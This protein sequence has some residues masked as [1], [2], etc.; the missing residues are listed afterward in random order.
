VSPA[1]CPHCI[2]FLHYSRVMKNCK[3][4]DVLAFMLADVLFLCLSLILGECRSKQIKKYN[5]TH[6]YPIH[7]HCQ[8]PSHTCT[9]SSSRA[10]PHTIQ[11][12]DIQGTHNH[13]ARSST[14]E[15]ETVARRNRDASFR[16][17]SSDIHVGSTSM[18]ANP[19]AHV[20]A[21]PPAPKH[22]PTMPPLAPMSDLRGEAL[23][24]A[25]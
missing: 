18:H 25:S 12:A 24:T 7:T 21:P 4:H 1:V 9:T 13:S 11:T 23:L 14:S 22:Q 20:A 19:R 8:Y 16:G 15:G 6:P 5:C 2:F 17:A 10:H 3:R